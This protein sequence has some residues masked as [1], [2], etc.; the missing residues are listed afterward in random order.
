MAK[1]LLLQD[2]VLR[3]R[4]VLM[5][6]DFNVP[7]DNDANITDDT[8]ILSALPSIRYILEQGAAL[9][10][11]SHLGRPKGE[12]KSKLS[13]AP[14][15]K[16][17]S[18]LLERPVALA[19]DC[20][21]D[22]TLSQV[23]SLKPGEI[24]LLE[25]LRFHAA[26]EQP[27]SD[28]SFA[29]SL[30]QLGDVYVNDAFGTAHRAH[31]S[32]A[33]VAGYFPGAAAAGLLLQSEMRF[34]GEHLFKPDH[35]FH[36]V[37]GG[38]KVSSKL[39]VLR[40]LLEKVDAIYLGGAMA[41]TFLKAQGHQVGSSLIEEELISIANELMA[42]CQQR[43][44][45]LH[46]PSDVVAVTELSPDAET[47]VFNIREGIADG[48]IG[49]DI[50]PRSIQQFQEAL[51]PAKIVLWNGPMGIFEMAPFA[52]G[53]NALAQTIATLNATT[54]VG[55]GD[56]IAAIHQAGLQEKF[57]HLSTGGGAALEYIE[58]GSLPGIEALSKANDSRSENKARS[59]VSR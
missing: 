16:R 49:V 18:Q 22:A 12:R 23:Q 14:C 36:A 57:S 39:G 19:A 3:D 37:I 51:K 11:M 32:T 42:L 35:P 15:A 5:R 45:A 1:K 13:L 47:R 48:W 17:L 4:K 41:F 25:N 29:A 10:L 30:A 50:G 53:T 28:A 8:R 33:T 27:D 43:N 38:K 34:L 6:V 52:K 20:V 59:S 9:V 56:S 2:L 21:G 7:L 46:L 40:S 31:S 44:V 26:E 58:H 54:I 55:G 24:L